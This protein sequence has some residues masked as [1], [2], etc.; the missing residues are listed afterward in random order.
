M[1]DIKEGLLYT[2]EDE[3]IRVDGDKA[4]IGLTDY[5]QDSLSDI[6]Y[7]ELPEVGDTISEG[8]SF[9]VV[10]SVK[11]AADMFMPI[12]GEVL[13]VNNALVDAP[14]ILNSD[15]YGEGWLIKI[16][17]HDAS[18]LENLMDPKAYSDY[19]DQRD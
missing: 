4:I 6:V 16:T 7:V 11:A 5:A 12:D 3:W 1:S 9:G 2:S 15:P 14:E 13:E 18:Q 10:E 17:I 19:C 8:D